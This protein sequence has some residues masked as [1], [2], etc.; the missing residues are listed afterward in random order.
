M[1]WP[2]AWTPTVGEPTTGSGGVAGLA[3]KH[4]GGLGIPSPPGCGSNGPARSGVARYATHT[5]FTHLFEQQFP[6]AEQ[7]PPLPIPHPSFWPKQHWMNGEG[8]QV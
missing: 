3:T 7:G 1:R 6:F 4:P 8:E 2:G 5:L